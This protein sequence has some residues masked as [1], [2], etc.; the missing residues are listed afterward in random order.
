MTIDAA[1]ALVHEPIYTPYNHYN[2]DRSRV[3]LTQVPDHPEAVIKVEVSHDKDSKRFE[4]I[5]EVC[6]RGA[7]FLSAVYR[8]FQENPHRILLAREDVARFNR[9]KFY[10]FAA[11]IFSDPRT[12]DVIRDLI[13]WCDVPEQLA[14]ITR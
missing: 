13:D 10:A 3:R 9:K 2:P 6:G 1:T 14:A 4:A 5:A 8:V 11:E 12:D 7:G